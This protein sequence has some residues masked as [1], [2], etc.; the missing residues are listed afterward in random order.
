ML[1]LREG[2]EKFATR[3]AGHLPRIQRD[4]R[5]KERIAIIA[6]VVCFIAAIWEDNHPIE[7][8]IPESILN[9]ID[10]TPP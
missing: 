4:N 2:V 3:R 6:L 10:P 8:S 5:M 1:E 7:I 9:L